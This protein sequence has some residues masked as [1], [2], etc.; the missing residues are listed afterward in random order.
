M[1]RRIE[2]PFHVVT[3]IDPYDPPAMAREGLV[4]AQGLGLLQDPE[5]VRFPGDRDIEVTGRDLEKNSYVRPS[6]MELARRMEEP[7]T[8]AD[9]RGNPEVVPEFHTDLLKGAVILRVL[10]YIGL[11]RDVIALPDLREEGLHAPPGYHPRP[12]RKS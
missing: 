1:R 2:R 7:W 5:G 4:I 10:R 9:G 6:F 12:G 11:Q 3:E 8:V